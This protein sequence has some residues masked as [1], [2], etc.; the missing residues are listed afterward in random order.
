M[1]KNVGGTDR[2]I[3]WIAG[4]GLFIYGFRASGWKRWAALTAAGSALGTAA[5]QKCWLNR[6]LGLSSCRQEE[7][8]VEDNG[9][10]KPLVEET[11][12]ESFPASDAPA[13]AAHR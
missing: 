6:L 9:Q 5:S 11:S 2:W 7:V 10:E 13:W 8:I 1:E 4:A 12:E 3:R